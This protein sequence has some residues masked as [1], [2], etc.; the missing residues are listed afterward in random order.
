MA[1]PKSKGHTLGVY[2][3][4][5]IVRSHESLAGRKFYVQ[6]KAPDGS[7]Y[8]D[9]YEIPESLSAFARDSI[10]FSIDLIGTWTEVQ[11]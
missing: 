2:M 8:R 1:R 3:K 7:V 4:D 6:R 11:K 10:G 5:D 9:I